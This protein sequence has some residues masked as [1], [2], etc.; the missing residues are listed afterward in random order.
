MYFR[1]RGEG[2]VSVKRIEVESA[3]MPWRRRG[4]VSERV[5]ISISSG[6]KQGEPRNVGPFLRK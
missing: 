4:C 6:V 5:R 3:R 2:P 1:Q